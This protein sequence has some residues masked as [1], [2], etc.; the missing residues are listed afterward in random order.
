[1]DEKVRKYILGI[2]HPLTN[3]EDMVLGGSPRASIALF[4]TAQALAA[5]GGRN[6][7]MPDDVKRMVTPVLAHRLILRPE[8]RLRSAL[9]EP[10][11][12]KL[13]RMC[14][15]LFSTG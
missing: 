5:I 15:S 11:Y 4:R 6:F 3:H 12:T 9:P 7:V 1:M 10:S 13:S 14:A 8:S 2:V